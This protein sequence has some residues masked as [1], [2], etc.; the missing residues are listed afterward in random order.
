M[1]NE[2]QAAQTS[3]DRPLTAARHGR[4]QGGKSKR[5]LR[6]YLRPSDR[7]A[8]TFCFRSEVHPIGHLHDT[9]AQSPPAACGELP[10]FRLTRPT[11]NLRPNKSLP[12][13]SLRHR[14]PGTSQRQ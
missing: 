7:T 1:R 9:E 8:W 13:I 10:G 11:A 12:C 5:R 4:I 14:Q 3:P 6:D 2:T